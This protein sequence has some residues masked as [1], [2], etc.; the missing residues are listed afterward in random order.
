[1]SI[2]SPCSLMLW[3]CE[4]HLFLLLAWNLVST[5]VALLCW[6]RGLSSPLELLHGI[7]TSLNLCRGCGKS[8]AGPR[9]MQALPSPSL[10]LCLLGLMFVLVDRVKFASELAPLLFVLV[11]CSSGESIVPCSLVF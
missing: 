4:N 1:M 5:L 7:R 3:S 6:W 10:V 8:T 11:D 2:P 9:L